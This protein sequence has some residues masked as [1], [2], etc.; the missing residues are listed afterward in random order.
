MVVAGNM[1]VCLSN[2][3]YL[4]SVNCHPM[5]VSISIKVGST[6]VDLED[7]LSLLW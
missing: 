5:L 1:I 4:I 7:M 6:T 2:V 3:L